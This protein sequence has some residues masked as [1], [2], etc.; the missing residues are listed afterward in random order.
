[1]VRYYVIVFDRVGW[2]AGRGGLAGRQRASAP[3][4]ATVGRINAGIRELRTG[5]NIV[6]AF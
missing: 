2:V 3:E 4:G 5:N 6:T 1:V